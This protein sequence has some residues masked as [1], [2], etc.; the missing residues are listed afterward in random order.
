MIRWGGLILVALFALAVPATPARAD[1]NL[2]SLSETRPPGAIVFNSNHNVV[3][4]CDGTV[5]RAL[6]FNAD[7]D[8]VC[9]PARPLDPGQNPTGGWYRDVWMQG[10][11]FFTVESNGALGDLVSA[12]SFDGTTW[13]HLDNETITGGTPDS[14]WGD[15]SYIYVTQHGGGVRALSFNG[16]ALTSIAVY[17]TPDDAYDVWGDGTYIYVAD[18]DAGVHALTF[19]GT[20]WNLIATYNTPGPAHG[21]WGDGSLI[22]VAD[23][24]QVLALTFNGTWSLVSSYNSPNDQVHF[25]TGDGTYIY[26]SETYGGIRALSLVGTTWTS[27]AH[28]DNIPAPYNDLYAKDG[29]VYNAAAAAAAFRFD[30]SAFTLKAYYPANLNPSALISDSNYI[31]VV[32]FFGGIYA[33][34]L[35]DDGGPSSDATPIAFSFADA[36]ASPSTLA[37]SNVVK[38]LGMNTDAAVS[39]AGD[40]SPE[41]RICSDLACSSEVQTWGSAAGTIQNGQHLQL[42][43]T[44]DTT[45][46][47]THSATVT[48]GGV[49]DQWDLITIGDVTAGLIHKWALDESA[50]TTADDPVGSVDGALSNFPASPPWLP[51]GGRVGGALDFNSTGDNNDSITLGN[52][53]VS[54]GTGITLSAWVNADSFSPGTCPSG[55]CRIISKAISAANEADHYWM[56][57]TVNSSG[58]KLRVRLKTGGVT[59]THI[60]SSGNMSTGTWYLVTATYDGANIKMYLD[61]VEVGTAAKTGTVSTS[62]AV[63]ARIGASGEG[64]RYWD[65]KIDEVRIYNRGLSC[66]EVQVLY[67][68][69][70]GSSPTSGCP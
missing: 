18:D 11:Y 66:A 7:A 26:I 55:D 6:I 21:V 59:T 43:L 23:W 39:I 31:Y 60:A 14:I 2:P 54:G 5:W 13:T 36:G 51:A 70:T 67:E 22:Y 15:G 53:D 49:S 52:L 64:N 12:Y 29:F 1:C 3:Q 69:Y 32:G 42:R 19:N 17:D 65:G 16:T 27:L 20:A 34:P 37:E 47:A 68:Y 10:G 9:P 57:S 46:M 58:T 24:G 40:G 35:C 50:G 56:F 41:Y 28:E 30:G 45:A 33:Y 38:I 4:Y 48:V 63:P 62:A 44:S 25:V 8:S 61:G